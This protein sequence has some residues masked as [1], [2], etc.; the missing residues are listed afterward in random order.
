MKQNI[1]YMDNNMVI[2]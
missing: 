2:I 1:T